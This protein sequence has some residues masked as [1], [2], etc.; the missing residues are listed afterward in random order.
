MNNFLKKIGGRVLPLLVLTGFIISCAD[1]GSTGGAVTVSLDTMEL[2]YDNIRVSKDAASGNTSS[3]GWNVTHSEITYSISPEPA[4]VSIDTNGVVTVDTGSVLNSQQFTV[5]ATAKATST[6]YTGSKKANLTIEVTAADAPPGAPFITESLAGGGQVQV[7]WESPK[8]TGIVNGAPGTITGYTVYWGEDENVD[9]TSSS[10]KEV[11]GDILTYT[12]TGLSNDSQVYFIVTAKNDA[13]VSGASNKESTTPSATKESVT[14]IAIDGTGTSTVTMGSTLQLS[15]TIEPVTATD[16]RVI[17]ESGDE[18]IATVSAGGL[19]TPK[20]VGGPVTMT[21][22]SRDDDTKTASI[23]I[24]VNAIPIT[25]LIYDEISGEAGNAITAISPIVDPPLATGTFAVTTGSLPTGL[26]LDSDSGVISGTLSSDGS[27]PVTITMTGTGNYEGETA[28][29]QLSIRVTQANS[30]PSAPAITSS[31]VGDGEIEVSWTAPSDTGLIN[32]DGTPGSIIKYTVY[33]GNAT[34]FDFSISNKKDVYGATSY[35][36][37]GLSNGTPV[38]FIVTAWNEAREGEASTEGSATPLGMGY[39]NT[40][41][42]NRY[43]TNTSMGSKPAQRNSELCYCPRQH[44][45]GKPR[46]AKYRFQHRG[47]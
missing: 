20:K 18:S 36:I 28:E 45:Y 10:K 8:N 16:K 19:V 25:S 34:G 38:Y 5:T 42:G 13:G 9:T 39:P 21:V 7:F 1:A 4:G 31:R 12:I 44:R 3:P 24:T 14:G 30:G 27:L 43:H 35:T 37:T 40:A 15:A 17:W 23:A 22:K 6:K 46:S 29:A 11:A 47:C 33:W 32:G 2:L 41:S 26:S